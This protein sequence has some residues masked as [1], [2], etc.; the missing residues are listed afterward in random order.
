MHIP[1]V[2]PPFPRFDQDVV[3]VQIPILHLSGPYRLHNVFNGLV[4]LGVVL[5]VQRVYCAL[6]PLAEVGIPEQMRW[7][8]P[9]PVVVVYRMPFQLETVVTS[10]A[11]EEAQLELKSN[12]GDSLPRRR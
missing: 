4:K 2:C 9:G 11:L 7:N 10:G 5:F 1:D 12:G 3:K 8:W 6:H